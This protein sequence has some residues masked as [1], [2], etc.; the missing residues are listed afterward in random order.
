MRLIDADALNEALGVGKDCA[1]CQYSVGGGF[2]HKGSDF[3]DAC[4]AIADA[5]T[6]EPQLDEWCD[7]CK[8]YDKERHCCPRFN[9]VIRE[10][11]DDVRKEAYKHGKSKGIKKGRAMAKAQIPCDACRFNP[12]SSADGKP[13]TMCPALSMAALHQYKEEQK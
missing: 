5:P 13:C 6:V 9:R 3:V 7:D 12:P 11:L 8:E 10:T 4:E 1:D 2:C